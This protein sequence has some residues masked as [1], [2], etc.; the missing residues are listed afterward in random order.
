MT[1][2]MNGKVCC[3]TIK[4]FLGTGRMPVISPLASVIIVL[5]VFTGAIQVNAESTAFDE[6]TIKAGFV[7]NFTKFVDWPADA[8]KDNQSPMVI[9]IVG[10]NP[11]GSK[12]DTLENKTVS[13]RKLVI[14]RLATFDGAEKCQVL[15]VGRSENDQLS[16]ILKAASNNNVLTISETPN[17]CRSGGMINLFLDGDKIRFEINIRNA[18]KARLKISSQLLNLAKICHED[19]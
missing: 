13:G 8:F 6:Y 19:N 9:C 15:F 3:Q 11:F 5:L 18:E 7:Y 16:A 17:F 14:R 2:S 4:R 1:M 12:I 10:K